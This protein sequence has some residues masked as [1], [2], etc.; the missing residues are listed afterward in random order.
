MI[1]G[2]KKAGIDSN[3]VLNTYIKLYNDCL[4]GHK[5]DMTI[6][7]HLCRGNFKGGVHFSEGGYDAI[8]VKLF[9]EIN[10][11]TYYLECSYLSVPPLIAD[12]TP[13]AG[14]FEPLAHLPK[15]KSVVLGLISSKLAELEDPKQIAGRVDEA[16]KIL[17]DP[18]KKRICISPQCGFASHIEGN[19]VCVFV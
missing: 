8:A 3:N 16:A 14:N 6:G 1:E 5:S 19:A 11:D 4:E 15:A 13:R 12:D 18:Q 7:L 2:M 17:G 10:C 9:N